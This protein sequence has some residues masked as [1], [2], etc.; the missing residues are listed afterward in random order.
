MSV[1]MCIFTSGDSASLYTSSASGCPSSIRTMRSYESLKSKA[2]QTSAPLASSAQLLGLNP[3]VVCPDGPGIPVGHESRP[4]EAEMLQRIT[5]RQF[6]TR[7][8]HMEVIEL[9]RVVARIHNLTILRID[10][11]CIVVSTRRPPP[12]PPACAPP[13]PPNAPPLVP[14]P[15]PVPAPPLPLA[16]EDA[17]SAA[18]VF[19]P[20]PANARAMSK[21]PTPSFPLIIE[22]VPLE[23][24]PSIT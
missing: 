20:Q 15:P 18:D 5:F 3:A 21:A 17:A 11:E 19:S 10:E 14:A 23:C 1:E 4:A 9:T 6:P 13:L 22:A 16:C 2:K 24:A 7:A 12:L 8:S